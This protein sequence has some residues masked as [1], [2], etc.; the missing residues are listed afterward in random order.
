MVV[1]LFAILASHRVSLD[2][3]VHVTYTTRAARASVVLKELGKVANVDLQ[4]TPETANE[5]LLISVKDQP[6]SAVMSRIATV[7]SG[8]W[9]QTGASYMLAPDLAARTAER[10]AVQAKYIAEV[11]EAIKARIKAEA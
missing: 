8:D 11:R 3:S 10:D 5:V 2:T 6:I 4:T 7:T 9:V 1:L